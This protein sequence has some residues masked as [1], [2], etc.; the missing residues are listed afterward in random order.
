MRHDFQAAF[1]KAIFDP[2][3]PVPA[4]IIRRYQAPPLR[5][6]NVYRNNVAASLTD[7]LAAYF[8]VVVRLLG[9]DYFRAVARAYIVND[10]PRSPILSR[11]GAGFSDFL[12]TFEPVQDVPYLADVARLEWLQQRAYHAADHASLVGSD[13]ASIPA[14]AI[15]SSA[16]AFH[17]SIHLFTSQ[18]PAVSIWRT[19]MH[20]AEVRPTNLESGGESAL[21]IRP[22]LEVLVLPL[23]DSSATFARALMAQHTLQA[24]SK[25]AA[26]DYPDFDLPWTLATLINHGA[27]AGVQSPEAVFGCAPS[28]TGEKTACNF[29]HSRANYIQSSS[30]K[31]AMP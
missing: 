16:F 15:S 26:A 23:P 28:D 7:V 4:D 5:R 22:A 11:Y 30:T 29:S 3:R 25:K 13:L 9:D 17:P 14:A 6:F 1:A 27:F 21:V 19:N 8:P 20:D 24:A 10:P 2:D 18:Y 31:G 12:A